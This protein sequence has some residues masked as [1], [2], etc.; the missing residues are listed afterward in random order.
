MHNPLP[1]D[2]M[3]Q[4]GD[5][6]DDS[7]GQVAIDSYQTDEAVVIKAPLAGV[8][9]EEL[10][11]SVTDEVVTIRGMRR[12]ESAPSRE[13]YFLQECYWGSFVRSYVLPVAVN[14]D[15]AQASLKD[16]LLTIVIPKLE[17]TKA[18]VIQVQAL[19]E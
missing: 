15:Q 7:D 1:A 10:E 12:D 3:T 9:K 5:W 8:A 14:A 17:K 4:T 18:R 2:D 19:S 11:V 6:F 16:G 13:A